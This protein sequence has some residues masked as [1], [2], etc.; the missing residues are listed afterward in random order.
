MRYLDRIVEEKIRSN[1]TD[2]S[3]VNLVG[4]RECGKTVLGKKFA[5]SVISADGKKSSYEKLSEFKPELLL[6]GEKPLLID[7]IEKVPALKDQINI[8]SRKIHNNGLFITTN[9][10]N[11]NKFIEVHPLSLFETGDSSGAVKILD[12]FKNPDLDIDGIDSKLELDDLIEATCRGGLPNSLKN[13]T[14]IDKYVERVIRKYMI[15]HDGTR[16]DHLK[17]RAILRVYANHIFSPTKSNVLLKL[18]Q[19]ECP[20]LAKSTYYQYLNCLKELYIIQEVPAWRIHV[21]APTAVRSVPRK[22]FCDPSIATS[23]LNLNIRDLLFDLD[24][25]EIIFKNLCL[26]DLKVYSQL[27]DGKISYYADRYGSVIDCILEIS[28]GDYALINFNLSS[29]HLGKSVKDLVNIN[30]LICRKVDQGKLTIRKPKFLAIITGSHL[31]FTRK[32][33]VKIIP[34]GV[35]G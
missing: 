26:R 32:D 33:G 25:Y 10:R 20:N 1:L 15:V 30:K 29:Q 18:I 13:P 21:K 6:E 7:D 11:P 22:A 28:N 23:V 9:S 16:R 19:Q 8:T 24:K 12:L 35:L 4:P 31:A 5:N 2:E 3:I 17:A 14:E 34:V 27:A